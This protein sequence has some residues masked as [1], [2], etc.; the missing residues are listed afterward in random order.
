MSRAEFTEE[1]LKAAVP[2]R[3]LVGA[4]IIDDFT[5]DEMD[6]N[7]KGTPDAVCMCTTTEEVAAVC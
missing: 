2:G 7:G 1:Q 5:H 4:D 6:Y 3:C